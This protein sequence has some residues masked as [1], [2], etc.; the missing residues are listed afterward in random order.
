MKAKLSNFL[1]SL[2]I[3]LFIS[4]SFAQQN[5]QTDVKQT[6]GDKLIQSKTA[7]EN[8]VSGSILWVHQTPGDPP[9]SLLNLSENAG[10]KLAYIIA[11]YSSGKIA[12]LLSELNK[13]PS[14]VWETKIDGGI[15]VLRTI[16]DVNND[17]C[18]DI[19]A[20]TERGN[21]VCLSGSKETSGKIIWSHNVV[22]NIS[23]LVILG[24]INGDKID[25]VI[26]GGAD[27][28]VTLL[29]GKD[30]SQLWS[31]FFELSNDIT[32]V[33]CIANAGDL[34]GDKKNDL[35][36]R[37]WGANR[38]GISGDDGS[39]IW[40]PK[41]GS[42]YLSTLLTVKDI[43]GDGVNDFLESGNNGI[44]YM[45]SGKDGVEI[46]KSELGRPVRALAITDDV[47]GDGIFDCFAGNAGGKIYCLSGAG[48]EKILPVW[49]SD[50]GDVV[51]T[52]LPIGDINKD[53]KIDIAA[54]AENGKVI[55]FSGSDG[56]VLWQLQGPD[57]VR[58][59]I[60][61]KDI[62]E[63]G[64][65]EI[66]ISFIDGTLVLISGNP[67]QEFNKI[68]ALPKE[69]ITKPIR[70]KIPPSTEEINELAVL[71][72]HD[73]SPKGL[74]PENNSPL[75]NFIDHMDFLVK[76]GYN[77]VTLEEVAD[78]VE[79]KSNLPPK[80]VCI[81]FDGQYASH[82]T[83]LCKVLKERNLFGISYITTDWIGSANHLDWHHLRELENSG[84]MLIENHT[85]NHQNLSGIS[86]D[87]AIAQLTISNKA[88]KDHLD[89]KISK[90]HA[91]PNGAYNSN[92][93]KIIEEQGFIT[94]TAVN[95]QKAKKKD[96]LFEIS[97][98]T[99]PEWM[100]LENFIL[101]M[102]P[103]KSKLSPLPYKFAGTVVKDWGSSTFSD[104][105]AEG[106]LWACSALLNHVR[107]FLP[108]G[109]E[110]PF[111]PITEGLK[112]NGEKMPIRVLSG[113][114]ITQS[115]E[116][117]ITISNRFGAMQHNGIFR[118][119][120]KDG[121]MLPGIDLQFSPG[122]VDIDSKGFIYITNKIDERWYVFSPE[123]KEIQGSPFGENRG[124]SIQRGIAV[125]PDG[126]KVY[127]I[128]ETT[129][130]VRVWEGKTTLESAKY[131][132][133]DNLINNLSYY[134]GCVEVMNDG[135]ILVGYFLEGIVMAFNKEHKIIGYIAGGEPKI[136]GPRG[137]AFTPDGKTIWISNIFGFVH[138]W[139]MIE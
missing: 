91:Y 8:T 108:D 123:F 79:G 126:S 43:N 32:Y 27:H 94:A 132:Q 71:L 102:E 30:G 7:S 25:D 55:A 48:K 73:V 6:E 44:L 34:N 134:C 80:P 56:K 82:Y 85:F 78:W 114:A 10:E 120:A 129:N 36:I 89:G 115:G 1:C 33:D 124:F 87:E 131:T 116:V 35:F 99:I 68:D 128:S 40:L 92:A 51:R 136:S 26:F 16:N 66:A 45:H 62:D 13:K 101:M 28:R 18:A 52:I 110:A 125:N 137:L 9:L 103:S 14:I 88:I 72:Y 100:P 42:P 20:S 119:S 31:R 93:K 95:D 69:K 64:I 12:C 49:T 53:N 58:A 138:K 4:N 50:I 117:L 127:I 17:K 46:W 65:S 39:D 106:K 47:N 81:T 97:R 121:K 61:T 90:H 83:E 37:T 5:V 60:C 11:G 96:G 3:L 38:W 22:F 74:K 84:V 113:I 63:D 70:K 75:Q 122:D 29:S 76:E 133:S 109:S 23:S 112:Q 77:V 105:D 107:I 130:D 2:I 98:L 57:T 21:I 86:R 24:D 67:K 139:E 111:S 104:V 59:M 19:V 54:G 135:T 118:Y 15:L 41:P